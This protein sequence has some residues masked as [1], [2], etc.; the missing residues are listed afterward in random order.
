[1]TARRRRA[2]SSRP[3][4]IV[5]AAVL[6]AALVAAGAWWWLRSPGAGGGPAAPGAGAADTAAARAA[7]ADSALD[8]PPLA[9]SDS[10]V[11]AMAER[12]SERPALA[13]WLATDSLVRR[14]VGA[15]VTVAAGRSPRSE[16]GFLA[17]EGEF[18]VRESGGTVVV[19]TASWARY[20]P[21]VETFVALDTRGT[22][23]L[24]RRLRPLFQRAY[25]DLGFSEG[26]F[27]AVL[28]RAVEELLA[29]PAPEGPV[30][31]VPAG[32]TRWAYA[33]P[34]LE[35]LSPAQKHLLRMGPENVRRVQRKLRELAGALDLPTL[36]PGDGTGRDSAATG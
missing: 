26:H 31:V 24:Y 29:V 23:R 11:R 14:F 15:V 7:A 22:A 21:V 12:L 3:W 5:A 10:L 33:D 6:V 17:P 35:K 4:G 32:A 16:L 27:D 1:M 8:L 9:G 19:D 25:R 13:E 20:D 34:R 30:E 28:A 2:L 36:S 18:R